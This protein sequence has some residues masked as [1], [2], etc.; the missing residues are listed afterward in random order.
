MPPAHSLM[1]MN[2]RQQRVPAVW[3][4][5]KV[6]GKWDAL[7]AEAPPD[8]DRVYLKGVW[9]YVRGSAYVG[10]GELDKADG[11]FASLKTTSQNPALQDVL[12]GGN[13]ASPILGMLSRALSG[14][15][16][17]ARGRSADAVDAFEDGV[18]SQDSLN[19]NEPPDWGQS[20]RLYLGAAL[21]K[22]GRPKHAEAVYRDELRDLQENG[23]AL[24]GL[25]QSLSA[26]GRSAKADEARQRFER[27]WK[28]A[29]V[30]LRASVF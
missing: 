20:M 29:D 27:A 28:N 25:W 17:M 14:E 16:A 1:A 23:W 15:I 2:P 12:S 7:L 30:V 26:Q 24:F 3:L 10:R 6:F 5:E 21:L 13:A 9:H 22:A 8:P 4:V 18:R 11:E 19:F